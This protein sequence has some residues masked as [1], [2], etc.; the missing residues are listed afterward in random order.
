MFFVGD[1]SVSQ[2]QNHWILYF[3]TA[4]F[5]VIEYFEE[6]TSNSLYKMLMRAEDRSLTVKATI[7][8]FVFTD[9]MRQE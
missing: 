1:F 6:K 2:I 5:F 8:C 3:P 9:E 7:K 4:V